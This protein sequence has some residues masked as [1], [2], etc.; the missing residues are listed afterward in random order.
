MIRFSDY[1]GRDLEAA[2]GKEWLE[3]NGIG[4]FASSTIVGLNTR[5]YHG[6]LT[7]AT[8]PPLG[9]MV[10]LSK[11][12]E[13]IVLAGRRV[14]LCC[15]EYPGVIHPNGFDYLEEF[16]LD[17][18]P[19]FTYSVDGVVIEKQVF[20]VHGENT[21][22]IQYKANRPCALELRPLIAFRDYHSLTHRN[23]ALRPG[24]NI[25]AERVTIAPYPDLPALHFGHGGAAT[26]VTGDWYFRFQYNVE[27]ER[28]LDFEEDLFNPFLLR[29]E[30]DGREPASIV[31]S[32]RECL[33]SEAQELREREVRRR[34]HT[35]AAAPI[36][37]N[38]FQALAGATDQFI[39]KRGDLKT[40]IAGYHWFSDWGRDTMIALPGL[41]LATGDFDA[42]VHIL[43]AFAFSMDQGIIPNRWPDAGETPEYNTADATLWLFEAVAALTRYESGGRL[44]AGML[45][46][47][48]GSIDWQV[49]G[50]HFGIRM[51][52]SGLLTCGE[53]RSNLTWM[54]AKVNGVPVTPRIGLP[55]E[56]QAL[57]YNALRTMEQ[58]SSNARKDADAERFGAMADKTQA[59][60]N[61]LFWNDDQRCL[62]DVVADTGQDASIRP[63]QIFALSLTYPILN[64]HRAR[65]VV[66][67]V[68]SDLLTPF[69][70]RTLATSDPRYIGRYEGN[71]AARDGAYHQ[72]T[73]WPWLLGPFISA[74]L[75]VNDNVPAA[76]RQA[77]DWLRPIEHHL[78]DAG[79]DQ[80]SEIFDGDPPHHPRGCIAQAW[81]V[82]EVLRAF[83]LTRNVPRRSL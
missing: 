71:T 10:L 59:S 77:H 20:A 11:I 78:N 34:H 36:K 73:V 76:V 14:D 31:V 9:R 3:T 45:E 2:L 66:D 30:L 51:L 62:Y 25:T 4:G 82:A 70:L 27:R 83:L 68:Q 5:R 1:P 15:N 18:F 50:T 42:A 16:R 81:S 79:L 13:T 72:G 22:V 61:A 28:G 58:L 46:K 64:G 33:T 75:R 29:M 47:L 44:S 54:D 65:Q 40:V 63:N 52:E 74:Y 53:A 21:T 23:D 19:T 48:A 43:A 8:R 26:E 67:R 38:F 69:G 55:V 35:K 24:V 32:T 56:I 37:S 80:I 49:R 6:L 7:A 57:W 60:F 17:P 12:E 41:I 39:V